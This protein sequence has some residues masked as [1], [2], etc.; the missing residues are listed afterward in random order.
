[1]KFSPPVSRKNAENDDKK[2]IRF[3][4]KKLSTFNEKCQ[5][6]ALNFK[7]IPKQSCIWSM[8][9]FFELIF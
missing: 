3:T 9:F 2:P 4:Q 6:K 5:E 7:N 1:M 8:I